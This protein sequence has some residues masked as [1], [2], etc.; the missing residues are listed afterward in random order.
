MLNVRSARTAVIAAARMTSR[1]RSPSPP[2]PLVKQTAA[3]NEWRF[4]STSPQA[5]PRSTKRR[6]ILHVLAVC[7]STEDEAVSTATSRTDTDMSS[8]SVQS[9]RNRF[10]SIGSKRLRRSKRPVW[11][12]FQMKTTRDLRWRYSSAMPFKLAYL[13]RIR[14]IIRYN[15]VLYGILYGT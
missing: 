3:Q 14:Y 11:S 5:S 9:R 4:A 15:T 2:R 1:N 6:A 10:W 12:N 7:I 8:P 13:N